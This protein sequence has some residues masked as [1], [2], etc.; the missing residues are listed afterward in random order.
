M[1]VDDEAEYDPM[2]RFS[3]QIGF[4][5]SGRKYRVD[6]TPGRGE[7]WTQRIRGFLLAGAV[8]DA[9]GAPVE[10]LTIDDIRSEFG[11]DGV[12]DYL[13]GSLGCITDDTQMTLFTMEA[14]IRAHLWART[15]HPA[16]DLPRFLADAYLRW[17]RT[18]CSP[19]ER[20]QVTG[21]WQVGWL[22][23]VP[24]LYAT[25][26][27]GNT[28]LSSLRMLQ[29]GGVRGSTTHRLNDS[30]GCGGVMRAA[31]LALWSR[32]SGQVFA[33]A[34]EAAAITHG[35]PSGYLSAG[36]LAVIVQQ[37]LLKGQV[38]DEAIAVARAELVKWSEHQEQLQL[39]D[40]AV[41]LAAEGRPTPEQLNS[42]LGKGWVGEEA[43]AIGVCA[44]LVATE[45][46]DGV[47][48]AVNHSGDSDSTGSIAG[49]ILGAYYGDNF[50]PERWLERLEL[51]EVIT[52]LARDAVEEFKVEPV[53]GER[54]LARYGSGAT[55]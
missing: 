4:D 30:K 21:E 27:P 6:W 32:D 41:A 35:H 28:C 18:Q 34:A 44:A 14:V 50:I 45:F 51:R 9:L 43:L 47:L 40:A 5:D 7:L 54:W 15:G 23:E 13:P 48:F 20:E 38:L 37:L 26:A 25:R 33:A 52:A 29:R 31:P 39:L 53:E 12:T 36:V 24:G 10:F 19:A 8:G 22:A 46:S 17:F 11:A 55:R 1:A 3:G 49:N 42:R 16:S 2:E